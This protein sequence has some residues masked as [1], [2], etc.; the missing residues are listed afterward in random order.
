MAREL[1]GSG[2]GLASFAGVVVAGKETKS[3]ILITIS[4]YEHVVKRV[5][6]SL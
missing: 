2:L 5:A 1:D 6:W 4:V 3:L